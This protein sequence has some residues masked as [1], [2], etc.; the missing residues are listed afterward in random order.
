ML[1][2]YTV[3]LGNVWMF[4]SLCHKNGGGKIDTTLTGGRG[5]TRGGD[6]K[7]K[8]NWWLY[9]LLHDVS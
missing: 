1:I 5:G 6:E 9:P 2:G 7:S 4:P 8:G 3:G